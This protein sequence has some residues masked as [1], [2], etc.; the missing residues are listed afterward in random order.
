GYAEF[1]ASSPH[2]VAVGGTRL[3]LGPGSSWS[4][5]TVWNGSGAGGGGCSVIFSA[6]PWQSSVA[7]FSAIGCKGGRAVA[8]VAAD[9]DPYSGLAVHDT[10][11][12]CETSYEEGKVKHVTNWCT[13]GGTSLASPLIAS[14]YALAG[15]S[16]GAP[17]PARTLYLHSAS[18]PAAL[19]DVTAGSN[20]ECSTPFEEPS[21]L[22]SC[23][24]SVEAQSCEAHGICLAGLG[25]D[26]PSGVGT[27]NGVLAF[28]APSSE[29]AEGETEASTEEGTH[30]EGPGTT[31]PLSPRPTP[32]VS[33]TGAPGSSSGSTPTITLAPQ[34]SGL[35]L[36][37]KA[38]IALNS[39]RPR[40]SQVGFIFTSSATVRVRVTLAKRHSK[41]GRTRW[42]PVHPSLTL[43]SARGRNTGRFSGH[44]VLGSG[45]YRLTVVPLHG[46]ARS[47][48]FQIG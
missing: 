38:V 46:A 42:S 25:Y 19:H 21:L 27:P 10:S 44:R 8:D 45:R 16:G 29:E 37:L 35:G 36:T 33:G 18:A 43:N 26:G 32:P 3:R 14:V 31:P 2:V 4:E 1:P 24:T 17:Y 34:I 15:G 13:I 48:V 11:P 28:Q 41:H 9:A 12:E 6:P 5:E 47:M 20:G 39:S 23:E 22:S 40:L 7:G 30:H